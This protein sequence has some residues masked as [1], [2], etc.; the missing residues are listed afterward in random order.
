MK[1]QAVLTSVALV[2]LSGCGEQSLVQ[3]GRSLRPHA[4]SDA[5]SVSSNAAATFWLPLPS[6][7]LSVKGDGLFPDGSF[8]KYANGV[9]GVTATIFAPNPTQDAVM[10][11]D[12]PQA[13]DRKCVAYGSSVVPRKLTVDY[14]NGIESN[15]VTMNVHDMGSVGVGVTDLRFL[16]I[17]FRGTSRCNKLQFGG[18][19]G[20]DKVWVT[21]TSATSWHVYSQAS[22][23]TSA[24][25]VNATGN[26]LYSN[27]NVDFVVTT[28]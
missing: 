14:G 16:G 13:G 21:R 19:E 23:L 7:T 1:R 11:T 18:P 25:C 9:C 20:G 3:P 28:P 15:P 4:A 5:K 6:S 8:S 12:N 17:G 24:V 10:Q 26:T 27:M 22:P 2:L